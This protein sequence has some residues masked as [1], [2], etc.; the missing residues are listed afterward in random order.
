VTFIPFVGVLLGAGS[1]A[2]GHPISE[3][4]LTAIART[5]TFWKVLN[6][7]FLLIILSVKSAILLQ[8]VRYCRS[9]QENLLWRTAQVS[10]G[11]HIPSY[12]ALFLAQIFITCPDSQK[13]SRD[14]RIGTCFWSNGHAVATGA[15]DTI[16]SISLLLLSVYGVTKL[17]LNSERIV[18]LVIVSTV[19]VFAFIAS[20]LRFNYA[21]YSNN[22]ADYTLGSETVNMWA[23][24]T[25][26][27]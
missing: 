10:L 23:Y 4:S 3:V 18:A 26:S 11:I 9:F 22:G 1:C 19:G 16:S 15:I 6:I 25:R 13:T 14:G 12:I 20:A 21:V 27:F 7:L 8:I 17:F 24:V 2:L 5:Y